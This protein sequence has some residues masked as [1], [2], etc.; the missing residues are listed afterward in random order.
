MKK[1]IAMNHSKIMKYP[2]PIAAG[3]GILGLV[4]GRLL[5]A[6]ALDDRGLLVR[7]H[8]LS[9]LLC[10]TIPASL[11]LALLALPGRKEEAQVVHSLNPWA[12]LGHGIAAVA[13]AIAVA[14]GDISELGSAGTLWRVLG[15]VASLGLLL[16]AWQQHRGKAPGFAGSLALCLFLLSHLISHYRQWCAD[17]QI[18]DYLFEMLGTVLWMLFAYYRACGCVGLP[19]PRMERATGLMTVTLCLTALGTRADLWLCLGGVLFAGSCLYPAA[20]RE[21]MP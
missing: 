5:Y 3:L 8:L 21:E 15:L 7:G 11:A 9:V 4:L 20:P 17:P 1:D 16:A 6:L 2:L 12:P 19:K 13:I 10:L 18:L 14:T